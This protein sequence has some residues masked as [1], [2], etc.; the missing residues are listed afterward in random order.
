MQF[1]GSAERDGQLQYIAPL[2]YRSLTMALIG[3]F[4]VGCSRAKYLGRKPSL[5][6]MNMRRA[7][8]KI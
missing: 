4:R 7:E 2:H 8:V 1:V 5:A 3:V 6:D